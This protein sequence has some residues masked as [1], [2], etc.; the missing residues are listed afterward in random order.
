MH[1]FVIV[2]LLAGS[3]T[4]SL[5]VKA[6][7]IHV[8]AIDPR[9]ESPYPISPSD[10]DRRTRDQA[11]IVISDPKKVEA[12]TDI[13]R[14]LT[15]VPLSKRGNVRY[16]FDFRS[17]D[18]LILRVHVSP[19]GHL[20]EGDQAWQPS[21]TTWVAEC[22]EAI[23]APGEFHPLKPVKRPPS[24]APSPPYRNRPSAST[25]SA[26]V[27]VVALVAVT[28]GIVAFVVWNARR[29]G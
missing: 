7:S 20:S 15:F 12:C 16:R 6:D 25:E 27:K 17:R 11:P 4:R 26:V 3:D 19:R 14:G 2:A 24:P 1:L 18:E 5:A 13:L 29:S 10:F 23:G 8:K 28:V 21:R 22:W 9:A